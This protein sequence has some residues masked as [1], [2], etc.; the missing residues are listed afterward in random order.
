[1]TLD[2][3]KPYAKAVAA[4]LAPSVTALVQAVQESSQGGTAI[5]G[6]EW[7]GILAAGL[8]TGGAVYTI[9]NRDPLAEHQRESVQPPH[10]G[11]DPLDAP[12]EDYRL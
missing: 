3:I 1:M 11:A 12:N 5:T 6:P 8:I 2:K 7:I 9:P 10:V 4:F